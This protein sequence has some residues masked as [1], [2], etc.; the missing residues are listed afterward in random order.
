MKVKIDGGEVA[1][2]LG[3]D[4]GNADDGVVVIVRRENHGLYVSSYHPSRVEL[5]PDVAGDKAGIPQ[6]VTPTVADY[7]TQNPIAMRELMKLI[8]TGQK[9]NAIK[10]ARTV[11]G[12]GLREGKEYVETWDWILPY[13]AVPP[14]PRR[15]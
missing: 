11:T 14:T 15:W 1:E 8:L 5:L 3:L 6:A 10:L 12:C 13:A 2:F 4:G 9:I 7:F